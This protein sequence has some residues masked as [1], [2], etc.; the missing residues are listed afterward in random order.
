[1]V[2]IE[3]QIVEKFDTVKVSQELVGKL[4]KVLLETMTA[5]QV[6]AKRLVP[7]KTGLLRTT[8]HVNPKKPA[9]KITTASGTDYG[10]FVEFGTSRMRSQPYLRP[11]RD[12][13]LKLDLPR[14]LK[15]HKL[16]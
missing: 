9:T 5:I 3:F 16:R 1:M 8:I 14:I 15:K 2:K 11:A 6:H 10:A 13:A 7:V 4:K 12:I